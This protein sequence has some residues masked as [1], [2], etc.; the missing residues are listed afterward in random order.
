MSVA[1]SSDGSAEKG[2]SQFSE[3]SERAFL[4][5]TI[6]SSLST[7][8]PIWLALGSSVTYLMGYLRALVY[9]RSLYLY[10]IPTEVF[11]IP[12]LFVLGLSFVM[13]ASVLPVTVVAS[14]ALMR[15]CFSKTAGRGWRL[16]REFASLAL[17]LFSLAITTGFLEGRASH[18]RYLG[19]GFAMAP[20]SGYGRLIGTV[21]AAGV[22]LVLLSL[23]ELHWSEPIR[24]TLLLFVTAGWF[25]LSFDSQ[26]RGNQGQSPYC[27]RSPGDTV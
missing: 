26:R 20:L 22:V 10:V 5:K 23:I 3:Q 8:W 27:L 2:A 25:W 21:L 16:V 17:V 6:P 14:A 13:I 7:H 18:L 12:T 24:W 9:L 19:V 1:G 11:P 4:R 15:H